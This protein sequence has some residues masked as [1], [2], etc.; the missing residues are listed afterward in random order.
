MLVSYRRVPKGR[1]PPLTPSPERSSKLPRPPI[2][3]AASD[4]SAVIPGATTLEK[5]DDS[6]NTDLDG[7]E[8]EMP[9]VVLDRNR[10]II[11]KWMLGGG[12]NRSFS[13]SNA[14]GDT[15]IYRPDRHLDN[16]GTA[17]S[18][19][20]GLPVI[21][22]NQL[23]RQSPL[24]R[25]VTLPSE[26]SSS[27]ASTSFSPSFNYLNQ[28]LSTSP[29][30][31]LE[32]PSGVRYG[33]NRF[34]RPNL[35]PFN[36]DRIPQPPL[37]FEGLGSTTVNTKLKD[38]VFSTVLRRFRRQVDGRWSSGAGTD[39]GGD[40]ADSE[41]DGVRTMH[42]KA[43]IKRNK[44][45]SRRMD[46]QRKELGNAM[47]GIRRVQSESVLA[48][49]ENLD[50]VASE[51]QQEAVDADWQNS[52]LPPSLSR[53]RSRS[54]SLVTPKKH[55]ETPSFPPETEKIP[56]VD[57]LVTRQ[58]HFILMEDLTGRLKHSCVMDLKMGT[59]QY[60]IDAT[61]V[62]KKSQRKKCDRTTSRSLGVRVCGMQVSKN[63]FNPTLNMCLSVVLRF[64]SRRT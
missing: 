3:K 20:L 30:S 55:L 19:D 37:W 2:R 5:D 7:N 16:S 32:V 36:S 38:H 59:R 33:G 46:R 60:G 29:P 28:S 13:H 9:E 15:P 34:E 56:K 58:N 8:S 42:E 35:R 4:T 57:P 54:R 53:R 26:R 17:S 27:A 64:Y 44:T 12:R 31:Y 39:D 45:C 50:V 43:V 23:V 1:T 41:G 22:S 21:N 25:H 11:P 10:H 14:G 40:M 52:R 61:S 51:S 47:K 24:A 18:P 6:Q 49:A 63:F 48:D 62:K